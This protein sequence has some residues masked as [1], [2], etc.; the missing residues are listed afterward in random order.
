MAD[1][2]STSTRTAYFWIDQNENGINIRVMADKAAVEK[3]LDY[4]LSETTTVPEFFKELPPIDKGYWRAPR[5]AVLL[6]KGEI[7]TP[8]PVEVIKKFKVD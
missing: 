6:L 5:N 7:V 8:R 3:E 1:T 4:L 2:N